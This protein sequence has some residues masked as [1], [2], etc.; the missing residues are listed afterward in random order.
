MMAEDRHT[1]AQ[2]R[3]VTLNDAKNS[4]IDAKILTVPESTFKIRAMLP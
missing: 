1:H 2:G 4:Q 3:Y